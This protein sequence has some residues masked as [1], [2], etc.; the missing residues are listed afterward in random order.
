MLSE[1]QQA[2]EK[3]WAKCDVDVDAAHMGEKIA[4]EKTGQASSVLVNKLTGEVLTT[5]DAFKHVMLKTQYSKESI[6]AFVNFKLSPK[7]EKSK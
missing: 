4:A 5:S 2:F 6:I 3:V 1:L 7:Q